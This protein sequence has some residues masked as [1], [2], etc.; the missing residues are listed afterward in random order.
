MKLDRRL[1][2]LEKRTAAP[3]RFHIVFGDDPEPVDLGS[4]DEVIRVRYVKAKEK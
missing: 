1:E 3:A 2:A 4:E